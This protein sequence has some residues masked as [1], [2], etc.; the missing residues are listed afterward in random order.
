MKHWYVPGVTTKS[1]ATLPRS[2]NL[3]RE[4]EH[5]F[6][7]SKRDPLAFA[8]NYIKSLQNSPET[9]QD[10]LT[11]HIF[12]LIFLRLDKSSIPKYEC[13][14]HNERLDLA[15]TEGILNESLRSLVY[16]IE[17][18]RNAKVLCSVFINFLKEF[19]K[20]PVEFQPLFSQLLEDKEIFEDDLEA[21]GMNNTIVRIL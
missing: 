13:L 21:I 15:L 4:T 3:S 10:Y 17:N 2:K 9:L 6:G 1:P 12:R 5:T 7:T 14:S 18:E 8:Y 19:Q 16:Q 11:C 20:T